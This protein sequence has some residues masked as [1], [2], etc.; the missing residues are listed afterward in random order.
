M[1]FDGIVTKCVAV[2]LSEALAGG[3]IEKI[4]Q[5][6]PDE[7]LINI[8]A[9]GQNLKLLMSASPSYPRMHVTSTSKENPAVPP[10]FC[11]LLRKHISGGRITGVEFNDFERLIGL[12]I[13]ATNELGDLT[14]KKLIIEIMGRHSNIILLNHE[15]KILDSIKHVDRDVS[16]VRE[17]MP[18]RPYLPP[19]SQDKLNP[20]TVDVDHLFDPSSLLEGG[21][22]EGFLLNSLKGFSPLL[23]REVCFRAGVEGK[24]PVSSLKEENLTILKNVLKSMIQ[25]IKDSAFTPCIIYSDK[26]LEA[27]F[28]FHCLTMQQYTAVKQFSSISDVL[29]AFYASKDRTERLKHK[30]ADLLKV[31]G[32]SIDRCNKKITLQ[33]EKLRDVADREKLKLFGE[34]ITANIYCIPKNTKSVSLMNYY[35][36][37]NDYIDVPLDEDLTPQENAQR[38]F[39]KYSKAKNAFTH[40]S[41]QLEDSFA[42]LEYLES[43]LQLLENCTTLPDI[44]EIRLELAEQGYVSQNR[45]AASKKQNKVSAPLHF[46]STDG[47]DI[48][49][50]KNNKQNDQLTLK[51]ASSNDIW[52]H[53]KDIPGSH[54]IIKKL[55]QEIPDSTLLEAAMLA[56][57]YSKAKQSSNVA[58]DYTTVKNVKKPG[59]AKPGMVN[60]ENYKTIIVTP[61][62]SK[63]KDLSK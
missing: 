24:A 33:Q 48:F 15:N 62:E 3:R 56:A 39:K 53:T 60:Y 49:I 58:V 8:R 30:K 20:E 23:C 38:Y 4:F 46:K 32:N 26:N 18:A 16:S 52:L 43:V 29:D 35:S 12:C 51:T 11:M 27:P 9:K 31:L 25:E 17:V 1:P 19:P 45:K 7:I 2:E 47:L 41:K 21:N 13:E 37:N 61:D 42:E 63:I 55:Q 59:G 57:Y 34:L 40:T 6:E 14:Y 50:G 36:E 44:S 54:V 22:V 28:D 5:P 10:V